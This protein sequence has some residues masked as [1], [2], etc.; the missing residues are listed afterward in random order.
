MCHFIG[1]ALGFV[2]LS[3]APSVG[4]AVGGQIALGYLFS[5]L[6]LLMFGLITRRRGPDETTASDE[7]GTEAGSEA[8]EVP[9]PRAETARDTE[10]AP[11]PEVPAA[12]APAGA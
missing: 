6:I 1:A 4:W 7:A 10:P 5:G 3:H 8:D 9:A 12:G 11:S 2:G